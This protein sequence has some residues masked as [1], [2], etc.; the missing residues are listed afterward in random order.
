MSRFRIAFT[1]ASVVWMA[2]IPL[3]AVAAGSA[4]FNAS[5]ACRGFALIAYA[6]GALVCHQRPERS[7][8]LLGAQLP[9]CA[10]CT[11]VYAGAA[12]TA[13]YAV[14]SRGGSEGRRPA[15]G[16]APSVARRLLIVGLAPT[17]VTVLLEWITG[18]MPAQAI[19]AWSGVPLGAAVAWIVCRS[20]EPGAPQARPSWR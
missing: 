8:H 7:F 3:A 17:A 20:L 9:V 13:I 1:M 12:L 19:R 14:L 15:G 10:R 16:I 5:A 4:A 6:I 2:T 11:G 18:H